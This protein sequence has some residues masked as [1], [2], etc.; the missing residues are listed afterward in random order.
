MSSGVRSMTFELT[1]D[2]GVVREVRRRVMEMA[3]RLPFTGADLA[4]IEMAVGEAAL[5]AVR[6]GSPRG[7]QDRLRVRCERR[8]E[9]LVVEI[10][11]E[12]QGFSPS[13]VP[14]PIAED[15]KSNGYGLCL[16]QGMMDEVE[17]GFS[18]LGGT[19]V[20]LTK[21]FNSTA[22]RSGRQTPEAGPPL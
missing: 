4:S 5:N 8:S 11:D 21:A 18:P 19:T 16:M 3:S 13:S 15:L 1:A 6:H 14:S 12:G 7:S 9:R 17:I 22:R 20:R 2:H 10:S